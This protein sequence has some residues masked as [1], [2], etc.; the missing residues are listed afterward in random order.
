MYV[1]CEINGGKW[2]QADENP[3][4]SDQNSTIMEENVTKSEK[5]WYFF[6]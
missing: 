1:K 2:P 4:K 3:L 5:T 6:N